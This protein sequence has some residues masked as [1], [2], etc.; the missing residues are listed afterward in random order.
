MI[1]CNQGR[2]VLDV[3]QYLS[4]NAQL[5]YVISSYL[6]LQLITNIFIHSI[7]YM[8]IQINLQCPAAGQLEAGTSTG[9]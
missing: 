7:Y 8:H 4:Y 2:Y 5:K 6:L 3:T 1:V 9:L